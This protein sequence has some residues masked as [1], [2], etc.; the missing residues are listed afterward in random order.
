MLL[1]ADDPSEYDNNPLRDGLG[2]CAQ[3][4]VSECNPGTGAL[5]PRAE[6][7]GPFG[8]HKTLE[9]TISAA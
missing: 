1:V 5:A 2:P 8:A 6:A 7:F 3:G 9:L 4:Q